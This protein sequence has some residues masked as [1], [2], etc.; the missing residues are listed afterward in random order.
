MTDL[1]QELTHGDSMRMLT[2]AITHLLGDRADYDPD[3]PLSIMRAVCLRAGLMRFS[4]VVLTGLACTEIMEADAADLYAAC[5][6]AAPQLR[7]ARR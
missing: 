2:A 4:P 3:E 7:E 1:D 6:E 5:S